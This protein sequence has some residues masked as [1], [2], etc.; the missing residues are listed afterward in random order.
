MAAFARDP[1][2]VVGGDGVDARSPTTRARRISTRLSR[3]F[4]AS[5][6]HDGRHVIRAIHEQ[7]DRLAPAPPLHG[8]NPPALAL[9]RELL[10]FA[11]PG[12]GAGQAPLRRLRR[13]MRQRLKLARQYW[14]QAGHP[15]KYKVLARYGG[16]HGATMGALSAHR[17]LGAQVG[18]RAAGVPLPPRPPVSCSACPYDHTLDQCRAQ[19]HLHLR[20]PRRAHHHRRD[21][22]TVAAVIVELISVSG[23]GFTVPP[24]EYLRQVRADCDRHNVLLIFDE[25]ITGFGRLG[26][27]FGADYFGVVPDFDHLWQGDVGRLFALAAVLISEQ[28]RLGLPGQAG[29]AQGSSTTATPSAAT[30]SLRSGGPRRPA[31]HPA[32]GPGRARRR[33]RRTHPAPPARRAGRQPPRHPQRAR[34]EAAQGVRSPSGRLRQGHRAAPQRLARDRG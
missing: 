21:P 9:A 14:Q 30:R 3:V 15:R 1:F 17:R 11:P 31:P 29:R 10:D 7:L 26:T 34:R 18:L 12:F 19:G 13:P 4:V 16:Y 20:S 2:V 32:A 22:E 25:I 28:L 5:V 8:T 6:G 24:V 27:R 23:A 33:S